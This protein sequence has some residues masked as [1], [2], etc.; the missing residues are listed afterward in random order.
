MKLTSD[1]RGYFINAV[2]AKAATITFYY[3]IRLYIKSV[4]VK[5]CIIYR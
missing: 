5:Y 2:S 3:S 1:L 4:L